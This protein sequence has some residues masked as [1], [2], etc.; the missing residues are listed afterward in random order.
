MTYAIVCRIPRR[1]PFILPEA[2]SGT[3]EEL[4]PRLISEAFL[5]ALSGRHGSYPGGN[6][7]TD[8]VRQ[9]LSPDGMQWRA[10]D[11]TTLSIEPLE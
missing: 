11:G 3:P 2:Y 7:L 8:A 1:A 10:H 4:L 9:G 5:L 6:A